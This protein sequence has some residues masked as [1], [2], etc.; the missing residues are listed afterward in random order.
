MG[1][2][3][4]DGLVH[5]WELSFENGE[6]ILKKDGSVVGSRAFLGQ[7]QST[8]PIHIFGNKINSNV[9]QRVGIRLYHFEI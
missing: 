8:I 5:A 4:S 3:S 7:L 6:A 2:S 1:Y 9:S